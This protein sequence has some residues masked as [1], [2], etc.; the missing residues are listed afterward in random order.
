MRLYRLK[1]WQ[2]VLIVISIFW[3]MLGAVWGWEHA[4]DR[5]DAEFKECLA[6][7]ETAAD[8]QACRAAR[9]E[10]TV[11]RWLGAAV[12]ALAPVALFWLGL[13]G[14]IL[15]GRQIRRSFGARPERISATA[16]PPKAADPGPAAIEPRPA[17]V[18]PALEAR[19]LPA[20]AVDIAI[21]RNKRTVE[22]Y[23]EAFRRSDHQQ[24]LSCLTD[25]V[26]WVIPGLFHVRGKEAF[27]REIDNEAFTGHPAITLTRLTEEADVVVAEGSVRSARKDGG[28]LNAVFCD[29]FEMREAKIR[30]LT[31]YF[32]EVR[33]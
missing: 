15:A 1:R 25:D 32:M 14:L 11:P 21:S 19:P 2:R 22:K 24:V 23:M 29:V 12:A 17:S 3:M 20:F 13:Y 10:A 5:V 26:E 9:A 28:T 30:K 7:I 18:A 31:S 4:N 8:V 6:R 16:P 33:S 27:D